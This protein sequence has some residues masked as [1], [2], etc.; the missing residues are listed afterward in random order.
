MVKNKQAIEELLD[1][2]HNTAA[3]GDFKGYMSCYSPKAVFVGTDATEYW[4]IREFASICRRAFQ[5]G[6]GW[7]YTVKRRVVTVGKG[8]THAWFYEELDNVGYVHARGSGIVQKVALRWVVMQYVLSFPVP[9]I[10][11]KSLAR[12]VKKIKKLR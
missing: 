8:G 6:K 12:Q 9:N 11:A 10:L 4:S 5:N 3:H 7:T 2:L 1:K